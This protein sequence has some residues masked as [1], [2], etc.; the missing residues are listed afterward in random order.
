MSD[1]IGR[2][3][4]G[5]ACCIVLAFFMWLVQKLSLDY[6]AYFRYEVTV[7]ADMDGY[8]PRA[9]AEEWMVIKGR[10]TGFYILKSRAKQRISRITL[11]VYAKEFERNKSR[12]DYFA[13]AAQPLHPRISEQLSGAVAV[14]AVLTDSIHV[15]L[16]KIAT[17]K[18]KVAF[19][20]TI[21]YQPQYTSFTS[22]QLTP[23]S[24]T[25]SGFESTLAQMDSILTTPVYVKNLDRDLQGVA[26]LILGDDLYCPVREVRYQIQVTRYTERTVKREVTIADKPSG[27]HILLFPTHISIRFRAPYDTHDDFYENYFLPVVPYSAIEES[28]NG[29]V[30]PDIT[31]Q[32]AAV[33]HVVLDPPVV[34]CMIQ[35]TR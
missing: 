18:C 33:S 13:V 34:A 2:Q 14:E 5:L 32:P 20:G 30:I 12:P 1:Q 16:R 21:S 11:P 24:V 19:N 25:V 8:T 9:N 3:L 31:K 17:K 27:V 15:S 7:E 4:F 29:A 28:M 6:S 26:E 10:A 23:D 35:K 22:M